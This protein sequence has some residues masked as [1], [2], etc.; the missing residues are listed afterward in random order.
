MLSRGKVVGFEFVDLGFYY[1]SD[2]LR[3]AYQKTTRT[4]E[5]YFVLQSPRRRS[6]SMQCRGHLGSPSDQKAEGARK[7]MARAF[8]VVSVGRA[9]QAR[10]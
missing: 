9:S 8:V 3:P 2:V 7:N 6:H 1:Y 4:S 5:R 10:D